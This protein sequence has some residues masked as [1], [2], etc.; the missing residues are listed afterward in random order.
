TSINDF[1]DSSYFPRRV[2]QLALRRFQ[3]WLHGRCP[4]PTDN[5][6]QQQG[7]ELTEAQRARDHTTL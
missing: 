4:L 1:L 7:T 3:T 6:G 5:N 2:E